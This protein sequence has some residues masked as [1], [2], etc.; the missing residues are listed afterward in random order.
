MSKRFELVYSAQ[1][2]DFEPGKRYANP[3]FF[4]AVREGVSRVTVI[5]DWPDVVKA[6]EAVGVPVTVQGAARRAAAP[7]APA[8]DRSTSRT[9]EPREQQ[10]A[11]PIPD[12]WESLPYLPRSAGEPCLRALASQ[13]SSVPILNKALA[14]DAIK[15][16]LARRNG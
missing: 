5:G 7:A 12:D 1:K 16:E 15:A 3:R 13:V 4:S 11:V 10:A 6:Y 8:V 14:V 9:A 2:T